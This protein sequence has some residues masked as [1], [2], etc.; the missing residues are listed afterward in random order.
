MKYAIRLTLVLAL[1]AGCAT[2]PSKPIKAMADACAIIDQNSDWNDP[3]FDAAN[4]WK[5]TPGTI[6]SFMRH[7]SS[8]RHDARP[9][10][11]NGRPLSSAQ[12][13]SQALDSTWALYERE[14]GQGKRNRFRDSADFI[15]WYLDHISKQTGIAKSDAKNLYLAYH[16]GPAGYRRGTYSGKSWLIAT[17]ERVDN[18]AEIYDNQLNRCEHRKNAQIC[19]RRG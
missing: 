10:D 18:Q 6:L 12:G 3:M 7:E 13:Y 4:K 14:N 2:K 5:I 15:G 8:F 11:R 17:A 19:A 1:L 16:E 9:L